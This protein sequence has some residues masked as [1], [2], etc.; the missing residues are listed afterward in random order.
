MGLQDERRE[1]AGFR[2]ALGRDGYALTGA[3]AA[4]LVVRRVR[5]GRPPA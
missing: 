3:V 4:M 5:K 2:G 1:N